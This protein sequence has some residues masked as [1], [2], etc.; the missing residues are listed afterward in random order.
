M[1]ADMEVKLVK[2]FLEGNLKAF[3]SNDPENLLLGVTPRQ[4]SPW[5]DFFFFSQVPAVLM[6]ERDSWAT[7]EER[8]AQGDQAPAIPL[9]RGGG[10]R[11]PSGEANIHFFH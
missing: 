8:T 11:A 1:S 6:K 4:R 5:L 7:E 9:P 10:R 2:N 3:I